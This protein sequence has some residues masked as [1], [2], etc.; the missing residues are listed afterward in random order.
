M[1]KIIISVLIL[2]MLCAGIGMAAAVESPE[3]CRVAKYTPVYLEPSEDEVFQAGYFAKEGNLLIR[4]RLDTGWIEA[5]YYYDSELDKDAS[6][7]STSGERT[8][9]IKEKDAMP[10]LGNDISLANAIVSYETIN[11]PQ[12]GSAGF[13]PALLMDLGY[14]AEEPDENKGVTF[15][16]RTRSV[17]EGADNKDVL[18]VQNSQPFINNN[19][20]LYTP[21]ITLYGISHYPVNE[22]AYNLPSSDGKICYAINSEYIKDQR[23]MAGLKSI[24]ENSPPYKIYT[25]YTK[26]YFNASRTAASVAILAYMGETTA[27][28]HKIDL[29]EGISAFNTDEFSMDYFSYACW[30]YENALTAYASYTEEQALYVSCDV[31]EDPLLRDGIYRSSVRITTNS[32]DGWKIEKKYLPSEVVRI[33]NAQDT[34]EAYYGTEGSAVVSILTSPDS[35]T[36]ETAIPVLINTNE[37]IVQFSQPESGDYPVLAALMKPSSAHPAKYARLRYP[38]AVEVTITAVNEDGE[39]VNGLV[40]RMTDENGSVYTVETNDGKAIVPCLPGEYT[41]DVI[42]QPRTF[43]DVPS[44]TIIAAES[45]SIQIVCRKKVFTAEIRITNS[46]NSELLNNPCEVELYKHGETD[47]LIV[48]GSPTLGVMTVDQLSPGSYLARQLTEFKGYEAAKDVEFTIAY[49]NATVDI[50][51]DPISGF[52]EVSVTD[53]RTDKPVSGASVDI[54][55]QDAVVATVVTDETG[56]A[57]SDSIPVDEYALKLTGLPAGYYL[58]NENDSAAKGKV[59]YRRTTSVRWGVYSNAYTV[60]V[61]PREETD[62]GNYRTK[63]PKITERCNILDCGYQII[64]GENNPYYDAGTVVAEIDPVGSKRKSASVVLMLE[65]NYLLHETSAGTG[66]TRAEDIPF[67][68]IPDQTEYQIPVLKTPVTRDVKITLAD[69]EGNPKAGTTI[70][71]YRAENKS[72]KSASAANRRSVVSDENG[73]ALVEALPYGD[74]TVK[75]EGVK[76]KVSVVPDAQNPIEASFKEDKPVHSIT[77]SLVDEEG[78]QV[79]GGGAFEIVQDETVIAEVRLDNETSNEVTLDPGDYVL[80]QTESDERYKESEDILFTIEETDPKIKTVKVVSIPAD[81]K[82]SISAYI[83]MPDGKR[84]LAGDVNVSVKGN[85]LSPSVVT[86]STSGKGPVVSTPV[87][88]GDY[89][90]FASN[91]PKGYELAENPA[92]IHIDSENE[93]F[94]PVEIAL[95]PQTGLVRFVPYESAEGLKNSMVYGLYAGDAMLVSKT[96]YAGQALYLMQLSEGEYFIAPVQDANGTP[97]LTNKT[98]FNIETPGC[99]LTV[100]EKP[101]EFYNVSFAAEDSGTGAG[102]AGAYARVLQNDEMLYEGYIEDLNE[103]VRLK[104]GDYVV[105]PVLAPESYAMNNSEYRFTVMPDGTI[106]G[107]TTLLYEE[108]RVRIQVTDAEGNPVPS[109]DILLRNK[110]TERSEHCITDKNGIAEFTRLSYGEH[111]ITECIPA[112]GYIHNSSIVR[113]RV[114]GVYRNQENAAVIRTEINKVYFRSLNYKGDPLKGSELTLMNSQGS[115]LQTVM[116]GEDGAACFTAVPYGRY[117]VSMSSAPAGYLKSKTVYDLVSGSANTEIY[118]RMYGFVCL[119][120]NASFQLVDS[121]NNGVYGAEFSLIDKDDASVAETVVTDASGRFE[122]TNYD[123]GEYI[124]RETG[125]PA[126]TSQ[127]DDYEL[128]V[129][130]THITN[131][132]VVMVT[133][134]DYYEFVAID[135]KGNPLPNILFSI[136]STETEETVYSTSDETGHVRFKGLRKGKYVIAQDGAPE[137]YTLSND[138]IRLRLDE[139][140]MPESTLYMFTV[141]QKPVKQD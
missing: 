38:Q 23:V 121:R 82:L 104:A 10:V 79:H 56:K 6:E 84:K 60:T 51:N 9:Y 64:A 89:M 5:E 7:G 27:L 127:V 85:I 83:T 18:L 109:A 50:L 46:S 129:D 99:F 58:K 119:P 70:E 134:P 80:R 128:I 137:G 125:I 75:Q 48:K 76:I 16:V 3:Y 118:S 90:L 130:K 106:S 65:G 45:T 2:A 136:K 86:I 135:N 69:D 42:S 116:T 139:N 35:D 105:K 62:I 1:R 44:G 37:Q 52:I 88:M 47:E 13:D 112:P 126:G 24:L 26:D 29:Y 4:N 20:S 87:P 61:Y 81:K 78:N 74:W 15:T 22:L 43:E 96:A 40:I 30:L 66:Y 102:L 49:D 94:V 100:Y 63:N 98:Q 93:N 34:A 54:M 8:V 107:E 39:P 138:T 71:V 132:T 123:Y 111:E 28:E 141:P 31:E 32:P 17:G 33:E 113:V 19:K 122:F 133:M 14:T 108:N 103:T 131:G 53:K 97:D 68:I 21:E 59:A 140:Y 120:K 95:K 12:T 110:T 55:K 114:D 73:V 57:L 101:N 72:Y 11:E 36:S 91:L 117:K 67:E 41:Y 77:V 124:I 92:K 25:G 115:I